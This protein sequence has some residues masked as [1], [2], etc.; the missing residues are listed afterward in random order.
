[1]NQAFESRAQ[2]REHGT[3]EILRQ[4]SIKPKLNQAA[5]SA[6]KVRNSYEQQ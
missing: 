5:G 3:N 4:Y 2:S 6:K 1:L